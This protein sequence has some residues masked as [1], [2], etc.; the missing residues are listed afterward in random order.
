MLEGGALLARFAPVIHH[1][2][3]PTLAKQYFDA[4]RDLLNVTNCSVIAFPD[5]AAPFPVVLE[6]LTDE[7]YLVDSIREYCETGHLHDPFI[8]VDEDVGPVV[9]Q[10]GLQD[11]PEEERDRFQFPMEGLDSEIVFYG[12]ISRIRVH[13]A[14]QRSKPDRAFTEPEV[15]FLKDAMPFL[16]ELFRRHLDSLP[17]LSEVL[18]AYAGGGKGKM[19]SL[20]SY[21]QAYLKNSG[22][23]LSPREIEICA[24]IILGYSSTSIALR[25]DISESTVFTHRKKIYTKMNISSQCELFMKYFQGVM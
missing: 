16:L 1:L 24:H 4:M 5:N 18:E 7:G 17:G 10:Y 11:L 13:G 8:P 23:G 9:L 19:E 3:R 20:L 25:L 2:G 22:Y 6:S 21:F 12:W 15:R 14:F